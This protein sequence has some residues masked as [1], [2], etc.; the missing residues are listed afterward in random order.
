MTMAI[1]ASVVWFIPGWLR[2]VKPADGVLEGQKP[3]EVT[4][5]GFADEPFDPLFACFPMYEKCIIFDKRTSN[6]KEA[7]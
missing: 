4:P 1:M 2:S 3:I 7:K 5:G 6:F